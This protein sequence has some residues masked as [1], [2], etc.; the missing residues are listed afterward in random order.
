M[1]KSKIGETKFRGVA[2]LPNEFSPAVAHAALS[3]A[4][5][6]NHMKRRSQDGLMVLVDNSVALAG[7]PLQALAIETLYSSPAVADEAGRLQRL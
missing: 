2:A 3:S 5:F 4:C 1:E 7:G 6:P